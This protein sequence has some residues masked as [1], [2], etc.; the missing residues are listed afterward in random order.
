MTAIQ[1][2]ME[3]TEEPDIGS[4]DV[5]ESLK[6]AREDIISLT[7]AKEQLSQVRC[8]IVSVFHFAS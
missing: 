8:F 5:I 7:E 4:S 2:L 1:E 3:A 6:K